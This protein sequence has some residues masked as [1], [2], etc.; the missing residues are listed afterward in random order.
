MSVKKI[1]DELRFTDDF[2]LQKETENRPLSPSPLSPSV[3]R[4]IIVLLL[5]ALFMGSV[6]VALADGG[7]VK[8]DLDGQNGV[9]VLDLILLVK[10]VLG[11]EVT[12]AEGCEPDINGDE[13]VDIGD[14]VA[15]LRILCGSEESESSITITDGDYDEGEVYYD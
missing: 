11:G 2:L 14:C 6:P 10:C 13:S 3:K 7:P 4:I 5:F 15:L 12:L 8:G 1:Y 9:T